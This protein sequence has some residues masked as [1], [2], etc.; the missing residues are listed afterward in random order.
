MGNNPALTARMDLS[1]EAFERKLDQT[2][3][4]AD[5]AVKQIED[6]FA[7]ANIGLGGAALGGV[8]GAIGAFSIGKFVEQV[9]AA[10]H[11]LATLDA[12]A[13][14][15]GLTVQRFQELKFAANLGGIADDKFNE[16]VNGLGEKLAEAA[17]KENDLS[18]L[19]DAN[20]VKLKD[21]KDNVIGFNEALLKSADLI[22]NG[23]NEFDKIKI[24]AAVGLSKEW[25]QALTGGSAAFDHL[26]ATAKDAGAIVSDET[27][28]KAKEFDKQ[29][30]DATTR[31]NAKFKSDILDLLPFLDEVVDKAIEVSSYAKEVGKGIAGF[32]G[33]FYNDL[34]NI[35]AEVSAAVN[36]QDYGALFSALKNIIN[37]N[38]FQGYTLQQLQA[39]DNYLKLIGTDASAVEE[40]I[41]QVQN[42]NQGEEGATK[43]PLRITIP[44]GNP[45]KL[46]G[47]NDESK[48]RNFYQV[49]QDRIRRQTELLTAEAAT[50]G[51]TREEQAKARAEADLMN[52]AR[53]AGIA[54]TDEEKQNIDALAAAYAK[55][56]ESVARAKQAFQQ[57]Q[58]LLKFSGDQ[59]LQFLNNADTWSGKLT[60][61][62]QKVAS[63]FFLA[64]QQA[65]LL[66]S[67][68]LAGLFGTASTTQGAVGGIFG[69]LFGVGKTAAAPATDPWSGLGIAGRAEGGPVEAGKPYIVGEKRPELFVPTRSGTIVPSIAA[70]GET[71]VVVNNYSSEPSRVNK[72][73]GPDGKAMI[74]V[75]IGEWSKRATRGDYKQVGVGSQQ[76][77]R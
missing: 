24:A 25:V 41:R 1:L 47:D 44:V 19:F 17:R 45:T 26:A 4:L 63:A 39:L 2:G 3:E 72:T 50:I 23:R 38:N 18:K 59:L 15:V 31:W 71:Q 65:L 55:Q 53:Q 33:G 43:S 57:Q 21:S 60:Q 37:G 7:K 28:E 8:L 13:E 73:K 46:P 32:G 20:N 5:R 6:T 12:N 48:S 61:S 76:T 22:R 70:G 35:S 67:G 14:K 64:A 42:L 40:R 49:A 54:L 74:E 30:S 62:L 10:N 9:V 11:E 75:V 69:Q 34:K 51:K 27:I 77:R 36:N 52:A 16:G 58:E 29:W 68:P 56:A 66:G